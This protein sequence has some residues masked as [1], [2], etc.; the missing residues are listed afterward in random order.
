M[1]DVNKTDE[2]IV[3]EGYAI[4]IS[5]PSKF[6]FEGTIPSS[7]NEEKSVEK[8]LVETKKHILGQ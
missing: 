2:I 6:K 3:E 7:S 8:P 4:Y 5:E 1:I